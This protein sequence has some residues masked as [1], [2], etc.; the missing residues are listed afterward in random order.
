MARQ[1]ENKSEGARH[2]CC[3]RALTVASHAASVVANIAMA[4]TTRRMNLDMMLWR[5]SVAGREGRRGVG[6]IFRELRQRQNDEGTTQGG[7]GFKHTDDANVVWSG[8]YLGGVC[9]EDE[10]GL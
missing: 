2:P 6:F 7:R 10:V 8:S 3:S 5:G 1:I 4:Q 9:V